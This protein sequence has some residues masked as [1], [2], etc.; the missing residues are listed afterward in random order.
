MPRQTRIPH[1][2]PEIKTRL[3]IRQPRRRAPPGL[4]ILDRQ[5]LQLL[6]AVRPAERPHLLVLQRDARRPRDVEEEGP[7]LG[8]VRVHGVLQPEEGEEPQ[9]VR[10]REVERVEGAEVERLV[11]GVARLDE[12]RGVGEAGDLRG[13]GAGDQAADRGACAV[14]ADEDASLGDGAVFEGCDDGFA[15]A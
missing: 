7:R 11:A 4:R 1:R 2:Q 8:R 9:G 15:V 5:R 13:V 14:G 10:R 3:I 12:C 6:Q